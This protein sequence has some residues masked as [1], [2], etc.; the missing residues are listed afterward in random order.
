MQHYP[1]LEQAYQQLVQPLLQQRQHH[2]LLL[3]YLPGSGAEILIQHYIQRLLC[4][5]AT[6]AAACGHC[7]SC[8]L[9]QAQTHPDFHLLAVEADKK[10]ITVDQVRSLSQKVYEHAQQSGNKVVWIKQAGLMSEAAANALLKTLEEPPAQTYFI[11]SEAQIS[12]LPATV[13]SRC[14]HYFLAPPTLEEAT[15]W[16]QHQ[17]QTDKYDQNQ[18]ATMLLFH[19]NSPLAAQQFLTSSAWQ[20]RENFCQQLMQAVPQQQFWSLLTLLQTQQSGLLDWFCCLVTDALKAQRRA[21]RF[22]TNRDHVPLVRLFARQPASRLLAW[23][24]LWR[25]AQQKLQQIPSVNRELIIANMLA[26]SE[27]V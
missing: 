7:H 15:R 19:Q 6:E 11:L 14:F 2:A 4:T 21:G 13:R 1:W 24:Q 12:S 10:V 18:L 17:S 26:Q 5:E 23:L 8:Q 9:F 25:D 20:E 27:L 22:I 3:S 16:L